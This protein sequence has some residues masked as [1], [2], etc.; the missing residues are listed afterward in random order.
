MAAAT[1]AK[2][3]PESQGTASDEEVARFTAMAEEWWD[4]H[5]KFRPL[6]QL[7][8]PR[9]DFIRTHLARHFGRDL[10]AGKPLEEIELLDVGC[11]GGLLS[12]PMSRL[13]A[14]V[15]GID[16]GEK[17]IRVATIHAEQ[18]GADVDYRHAKPEDLVIEGRTFDV[19][20][21]M[22]VIEH[23][24]DLDL[25]IEQTAKLL[26]PGGVMVLSTVNRT[27]KALALAK[28]GAEYVLRWL[29]RGTHDWNKFVKP[30]ELARVLAAHGLEVTDLKGMGYNPLAD[31]WFMSEN[32][33]MNYMALATKG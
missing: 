11:G 4:P 7:N 27:F 6:H 9:I 5:G 14:S 13:G 30:S 31:V 24:P 12:E 33:D 10:A 16:A 21:N 26:R 25:F 32:L 22:E 8:P 3:T 2:D 1:E 29:P 17:N 20:L 19:V 15:T 28:F 18:E 23:V